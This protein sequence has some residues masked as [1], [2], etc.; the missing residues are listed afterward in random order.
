MARQVLDLQVEPHEVLHAQVLGIEAALRELVRQAPSICS[1]ISPKFQVLT[2]FESLSTCSS[3]VA[4]RFADFARGGAV[5]VGDDVR[6]H[7]RAVR[8]VLRVDVLDD[9][10]A[11]VARREIEV[12]VRP[13][14]A[15]LGQKALEEQL[16]LHR[17]DGGDAERVADRAVG[18]GAAPLHED[19]SRDCRTGRCPRR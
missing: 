1:R 3:G 19:R 2:H 10:L 13:L 5:A 9:F 14:A 7:R 17:I 12:D 8:A 4:E 6:G 16:H 11:L 18:R 15:L